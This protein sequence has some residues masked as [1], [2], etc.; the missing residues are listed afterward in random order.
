L[1]FKIGYNSWKGETILMFATHSEKPVNKPVTYKRDKESIIYKV[2]IK[3]SWKKIPLNS[4][5]F[6]GL[7]PVDYYFR[8]GL[9]KYTIGNCS[10]QNECETFRLL[11]VKHG[12]EDAFVVAFYQKNRISL[13]EA[14]K[15]LK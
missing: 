14:E 1:D 3:S 7:Q 12:F 6:E 4:N 8:D 2:Q 5:L 10:N 11:A 15:M 13:E 9:Y